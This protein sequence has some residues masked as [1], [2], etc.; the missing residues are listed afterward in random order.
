[1]G[2]FMGFV[3]MSYFILDGE[4][5]NVLVAILYSILVYPF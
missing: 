2:I 3:S 4:F 5:F 1:M